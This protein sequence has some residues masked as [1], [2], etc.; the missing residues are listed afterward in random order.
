MQY[1]TEDVSLVLF[2]DTTTAMIDEAVTAVADAHPHPEKLRDVF[3]ERR[4]AMI[5]GELPEALWLLRGDSRFVGW[6][7][8]APY[9]ERPHCWQTTT[10][11]AAALRG[12]GLFERARC[13]Q[14][15]AADIVAGWATDAGLPQATFMLS[16]ADWNVRSLR[17]SRRY[18][19][20]NGW[21]DTWEQVFEPLAERHAHV[22][23]FP[24]PAAVHQCYLPHRSSEE[25][26]TLNQ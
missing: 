5:A 3:Y 17:A 6:V 23:T 15:H 10:Y 22:F 24:Y 25:H 26:E 8:W 2:C 14:I 9:K 21:M 20:S 18:A 7:G 19:A 1:L 11:F 16:I 13:H 4:A 12:T